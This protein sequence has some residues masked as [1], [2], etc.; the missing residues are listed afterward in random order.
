MSLYLSACSINPEVD[1]TSLTQTSERSQLD[2]P[3]FPQEEF[4]CGPAALA[5]LLV[6]S[7]VETT[8]DLLTP[9]IYLPERQ[10]SLQPELLAASRRAGRV[11][12]VIENDLRPVFAQLESGRPVLLLQNLRTQHFPVW[13]YAVLTGYEPASRTVFMNTG[14]RQNEAMDIRKF[15]R[16]WDWAGNWALVVL[17]P[18]E[19]PPLAK[20][21]T[22]FAAVANFEPVAGMEPAAAAWRSAIEHWPDQPQPY[23][24][25]G[26]QAYARGELADAARWYRDGLEVDAQNPGLANNFAAVL[27]EL[28]CPRNGENLLQP[29]AAELPAASAWKEI[30]ATTL[31]ELATVPQDSNANC[32]VN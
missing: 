31:S 18:G 9:Q 2:V 29:L 10:G 15:A 32:A 17:K 22:Y 13:H 11:P 12:Y 21:E 25:L 16:L 4:Q 27:G 3:F 7:G 8:P 28:G 30:I 26:N 14:T 24:A 19:I 20:P 6:A 1:S 23:L 5:T